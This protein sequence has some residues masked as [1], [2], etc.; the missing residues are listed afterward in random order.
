MMLLGTLGGGNSIEI[1][2]SLILMWF[3]L[4]ALAISIQFLASAIVEFDTLGSPID[5]CTLF[6]T[7]MLLLGALRSEDGVEI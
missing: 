5:S 7:G 2:F 4:L 6:S 3:S 1:E